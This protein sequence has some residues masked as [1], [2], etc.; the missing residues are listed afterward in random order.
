ME[1]TIIH[2]WRPDP[3]G[4]NIKWEEKGELLEDKGDYLIIKW[5]HETNTWWANGKVLNVSKNL[6]INEQ[7]KINI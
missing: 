7:L 3:F 4:N 6:I 5:I 2:F 1:K